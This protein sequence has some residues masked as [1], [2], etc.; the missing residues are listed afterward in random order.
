M[1]YWCRRCRSRVGVRVPEWRVNAVGSPNVGGACD[2]CGDEVLR[3]ITSIG[4]APPDIAAEARASGRTYRHWQ[5]VHTRERDQQLRTLATLFS[6][7]SDLVNKLAAGFGIHPK[8]VQK[9]LRDGW[10]Y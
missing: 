10:P 2:R 9:I 8:R 4:E 3:R 7:D 1:R 6:R 5:K